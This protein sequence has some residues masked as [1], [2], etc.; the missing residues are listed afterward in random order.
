MRIDADAWILP[1]PVVGGAI[2]CV[3]DEISSVWLLLAQSV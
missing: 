2:L 1:L 3:A